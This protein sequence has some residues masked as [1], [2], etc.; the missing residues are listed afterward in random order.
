VT[1]MVRTDFYVQG[2]LHH[3]LICILFAHFSF[4]CFPAGFVST[5]LSQTGSFGFPV[6]FGSLSCCYDLKANIFPNIDAG[7]S[8]SALEEA[9]LSNIQ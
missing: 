4:R 9:L 1:L 2:F 5:F 3:S 7:I 6:E 8:Q